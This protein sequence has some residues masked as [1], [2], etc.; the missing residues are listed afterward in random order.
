MVILFFEYKLSVKG[1]SESEVKINWIPNAEAQ[2]STLV[3]NVLSHPDN[4]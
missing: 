4:F 1:Y 2:L 3:A